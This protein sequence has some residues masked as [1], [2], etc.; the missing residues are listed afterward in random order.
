MAIAK[1]VERIQC[2]ETSQIDNVFIMVGSFHIEMACFSSPGKIIDGSGGPYIL[3]EISVVAMGAINKF[4]RGKVYHRC[5]R[6][7]ILLSTAIHGL[8]LEQFFEHNAV[9]HEN[10]IND[11]EG[12]K[13]G[14]PESN[15]FKR[16]FEKYVTYMEETMAESYGKT[17]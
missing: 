15:L 17:A 2:E 16:L 1:I 7:Y 10:F 9:I 8:H 14:D 4:L 6:G 13:N 3:S 5:S 12:W 11:L